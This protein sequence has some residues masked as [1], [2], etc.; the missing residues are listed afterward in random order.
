MRSIITG[1]MKI[2]NNSHLIC[3]I[4]TMPR[5]VSFSFCVS[6]LKP[7]EASVVWGIFLLSLQQN[8]KSMTTP[9]M[10]D[11]ELQYKPAM[12]SC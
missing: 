12:N 4:S 9:K 3:L 5:L 1:S 11:K 10:I 8:L 6:F 7:M 2:C